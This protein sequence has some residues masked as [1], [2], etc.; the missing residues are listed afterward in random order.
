LPP[1]CSPGRAGGNRGR[2][3]RGPAGDHVI[4][5]VRG[6]GVVGINGPAAHLVAPGDL[7]ILISYGT[8]DE[9]ESQHYLLQ[10]ILDTDNRIVH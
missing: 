5:G 4:P 2:H 8:M 6:S 1:I 3:Q 7:V 10:V 9:A